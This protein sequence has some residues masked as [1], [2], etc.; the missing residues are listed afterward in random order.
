VDEYGLEIASLATTLARLRAAEA[1]PAIID[2]Y[3]AELRNLR[4]LYRAAQDTLMA[5]NDDL[6]LRSALVELGFGDWTLENVYSFVYEAAMDADTGERELASL[7]DSIDFV[8]SLLE[9]APNATE[10]RDS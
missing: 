6:R 1:E 9:D 8:A 5:G 4:A 2:E 3:E 7:V 10:A